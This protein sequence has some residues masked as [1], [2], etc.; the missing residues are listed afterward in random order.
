M[1]VLGVLLAPISL[2]VNSTCS[3][4]PVH[5][6]KKGVDDRM[7]VLPLA[8][9]P[10]N[11]IIVPKYIPG[12]ARPFGDW[13][14]KRCSSTQFVI[15][16]ENRICVFCGE[17]SYYEPESVLFSVS[18]PTRDFNENSG[19]R[20][21]H[22]KNW[23]ARLQG[24]EKCKISSEELESVNQLVKTYPDSISEFKRIRMALRELKLQKYYN[25]VYYI[26]NFV[27][28]YSLVRFSKINEARLLA[29][30]LKIQEP[31]SRIQQGRV[32]M[33]SYQFLIRKFCQ[34]LGYSVYEYIP[35]MSSRLN[36]QKQDLIW[37][38]IC[39]CL[40]LPF[41]PSV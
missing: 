20:V 11:I 8:P 34:L 24:K 19:K 5:A 23:V 12:H 27:F 4:D 32:N 40:G 35:L 1:V 2:F 36:L 6:R 7:G 13:R 37:S 26:M 21:A 16:S 15:Q 9:N 33:L 29:L 17:S 39:D 22:F 30:F 14:C 3:I 38:Q 41:Y 28:G 25:N 18:S 31:F 10:C